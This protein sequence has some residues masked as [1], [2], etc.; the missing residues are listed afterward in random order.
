M[1]RRSTFPYSRAKNFKIQSSAALKSHTDSDCRRPVVL[2]LGPVTI[3]M[4]RH[5][6]CTT[7][8]KPIASSTEHSWLQ[9]GLLKKSCRKPSI[10]PTLFCYHPPMYAG[11]IYIPTLAHVNCRPSLFERF[12][13]KP[14]CS[15]PLTFLAPFDVSCSTDSYQQSS[16]NRYLIS[17]CLKMIF[18]VF[19]EL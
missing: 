7:S 5:K 3:C 16:D 14:K 9:T 13:F 10:M 11:S 15:Q 6:N 12:S 19:N 1:G 18:L 2:E 17:V 8:R 4:Q